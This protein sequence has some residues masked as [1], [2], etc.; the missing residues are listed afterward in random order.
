MKHTKFYVCPHCGSMLQGMAESQV[1]CCGKKLEPLCAAPAQKEHAITISET[2]N[3]YY[4]TFSHEMTK[5]HFIGFVSCVAGDRVLTIKLY[6]EQDSSV[7]FSKMYGGKIYFYCSRHG[8]FSYQPGKPEQQSPQKSSGLTAYMSA[9]ARVYHMKNSKHPLLNDSMTGKLFLKEEYQTLMDYIKKAGN[10]VDDY[11]RTNLAPTPVLREVFG[12][13]CFR[14][15]VR[16][17]TRQYVM[18]GCGL[19]TFSLRQA[20][21]Q[22]EFFEIDREEQI[23]DKLSRLKRAGID[24]PENVHFIAADFAVDSLEDVLMA[25]GFDPN[26]KTFFS[27]MGL[28]YYLTRRDINRLLES[29]SHLSSDGSTLVFDTPDSHLFSSQVPRVKNMVLM[30]EKSG[31]TMQSCFGYDELEK[32]LENH[33]FLLY[34]FLNSQAIQERYLSHNASDMTAFEHINF[35]EAVWKK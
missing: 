32:L 19:D 2:E 16:T 7:R 9:F 8:L 25:H 3:D 1:F 21:L 11:V 24:V 12:T 15:A 31:E 34:E 27:C 6:P 30:A 35:V 14:T 33:S 23:K 28:F 29:V 5:E 22:L 10:N 18:L 17:G 13:D 4:I 26:K 20:H